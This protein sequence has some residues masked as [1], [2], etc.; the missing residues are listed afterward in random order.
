MMMTRK[1]MI[2]TVITGVIIL[3]TIV[4]QTFAQ[5]YIITFDATGIVNTVDSIKVENLSQGTSITINGNDSL[6]LTGPVDIKDYDIY[7]RQMN[8]Y[9]NP[10]R[11]GTNISFY[12]DRPCYGELSVYNIS[13]EALLSSNMFF[14]KGIQSIRVT[15][16]KR[17]IYFV[18]VSIENSV[19]TAKLVSICNGDGTLKAYYPGIE[20]SESIIRVLK[21][22]KSTIDM[23]YNDG[24]TL[25]FTGFS[26]TYSSVITAIPTSDKIITF[27]FISLPVVTTDSAT[28]ITTNTALCGGNVISDGGDTITAR[29]VC[30]SSLPNPDTTSNHTTDGTG[31]GLFTSNI[32]GLLPNT[33]YYARAYAT[34]KLGTAYGNE[35]S[36]TTAVALVAIGD[37][38]QGGIVAY[39]LQPGD[40]GYDGSVQ[41]GLIATPSDQNSGIQWYN[42]ISIATG[43]VDTA[44]GTGYA[45][46]NMIVSVQG[47]GNYAAQ[48][49]YDL[50][51][52]GYSD[53]YLPSKDELNKL[54]LS[55]TIVG[56]YTS[57]LYWA[58]TEVS[59]TDACI[60]SFNSGHQLSYGKN[61]PTAVRPIRS[62]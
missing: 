54:F 3:L 58:S 41:H 50:V 46:T 53:W 61:Y 59:A 2:Y 25:R 30:W 21:R 12:N 39:I 47:P 15:G 22:T 16:F 26:D 31:T 20:D 57:L 42:G 60:Q 10:S 38:Y 27:V 24:D 34:N 32:T 45:N 56:G 18:N 48:L 49:C 7:N 40:P 43:A 62:F 9:P 52:N 6:H 51:L 17:G 36:F 1:S 29:G 14:T 13:G 4:S 28:A 44:L 55:K 8:I 19:Y 33:I 35:I 37:S 11:Y 5:N 23:T